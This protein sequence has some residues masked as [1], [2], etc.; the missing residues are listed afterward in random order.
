LIWRLIALAGQHGASCCVADGA[1]RLS[2]PAVDL[3]KPK[4]VQVQP[5]LE[6][7]IAHHRAGKLEQAEVLYRQVIAEDEHQPDALHLLGLIAHQTGNHAQAAELI[8]RAILANPNAPQFYANLGIVSHAAGNLVEATELFQRAVD[9][10]PDFADALNNLG[11][12][13]EAQG[14]REEAIAH[15]RRAALARP[16][17][18]LAHL[19]LA[20]AL[21]KSRRYE[22]ATLEYQQV[23]A[24]DP[25]ALAVYVELANLLKELGRPAQAAT[26]Y[27]RALQVQPQSAL[28]YSNLGV[29][30]RDLTRLEDSLAAHR[31]AVEL[32]P[33][34]G[35]AQLNYA[36]TLIELGLIDEGN[37]A[38]ARAKALCPDIQSA[39]STYLL[40]LNYQTHSAEFLFEEHCRW[41]QRISASTPRPQA[42]VA[43][44]RQGRLRV[45]YVS[46][47]FRNHP[48]AFFLEP[49]VANHDP[50][51]FEVICYSDV[52]NPDALTRRLQSC[53]HQW[54]E[55]GGL[56]RDELVRQ[57]QADQIDIL[58][59]LSGHT[60]GNRLDV[61]AQKPAPMQV[62]YLG[63]PA[64]TGL[65][66][67]G[68]RMTDAIADPVGNSDSRHIEKLIR[69]PQTLA[70]YSPP[71]D[72]PAVDDLPA[73]RRGYVTFASFTSLA[74][75]SAESISLWSRVLRAV[76]LSRL[77]IT[78]RGAEATVTQ[79]RL[80][81]A[82]AR[83]DISSSRLHF[84][85]A[86]P[87]PAYLAFHNEV[88][89][90]LDS[91]PFNGHTTACHALWM[92][93]PIVTQSG[94]R[95]ASR[96]GRSVLTNAGLEELC[97]ESADE[98]ETIA[99][100]LA[101][102]IP[103][104]REL[105]RSMRERLSGSALLNAPA[106]ANAVEQLLCEQWQR[107]EAAAH[108]GDT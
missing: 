28:I 27:E 104:L 87:L 44:S 48:I 91:I 105:R 93:V 25:G 23:I 43:S 38:A 31:R 98:F 51:R 46:A 29:A 58:F 8:R 75:I 106:F 83:H 16:G 7:A 59:D 49:L 26:W 11:S 9:L 34:L 79:Q 10:D 57:I 32:D 108:A 65:A 6:Q 70:C 74:K 30:L 61:F 80:R 18:A 5:L 37:A 71:V 47:D 99:V 89:V 69:L 67:I 24:L 60:A 55:T 97:A 45:G 73:E 100:A 107:L 22:E 56:S 35:E 92:G 50:Q 19:N 3:Q 103:R 52:L 94:D 36:V 82:F 21:R 72:A 33:N 54:R 88:D 64:T 102:D 66:A 84:R 14:R 81:G 68:Y 95:F 77:A 96:L 4:S 63:Y 1:P 78:A 62:A 13:L 39:W 40:S 53:A 85:G 15:Y 17:F 2:L 90:V 76:P 86:T 41:G 12:A 20:V 42:F 101:G